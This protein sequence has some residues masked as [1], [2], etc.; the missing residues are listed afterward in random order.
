[1]KRIL[2]I[3]IIF[4]CSFT[5]FAQKS[6]KLSFVG[7]IDISHLTTTKVKQTEESTH[8]IFSNISPILKN[9]QFTMA[10]LGTIHR[11][12]QQNKFGTKTTDSRNIEIFKGLYNNH[13]NFLNLSTIQV[14]PD[15]LEN[16]LS[17]CA[18]IKQTSINFVGIT[19]L[20]EST[21]YEHDGITYGV[22][23]FG[24]NPYTP[25]AND[26]VAIK[27]LI[28][29][30]DSKCDIVV[31][32]FNL[33]NNQKLNVANTPTEKLGNHIKRARKF[34][35]TCIDSGADIVIGNGYPTILP[36]ELY[37]D[38]LI[39]YGLGSFYTRP[40]NIQN[41][42][43]LYSPVID[44]EMYSD[45]LFKEAQIHS[46]KK[47]GI[48][49]PIADNAMHSVK[50]IKRLSQE[51]VNDSVLSI[52]DNGKIVSSLMN[53]AKLTRQLIDI[54]KKHIGKRYR[55]GTMGPMTFD[56]SGFTSY[57]YNQI[58]I[59]LK[60]SSREQYTMGESVDRSKLRPGDLVFFKGSATAR[61][62]NHVGI[63]VSVDHKTNNF[64]FIHATPSRGIVIDDYGHMAYYIKRYVGA[65]RIISD[66]KP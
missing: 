14:T 28:T 25:S 17:A 1:M 3:I 37:L 50:T 7:K 66:K 62:I 48:S 30:L 36:V 8:N 46:F 43:R 45:G 51:Y 64:K 10:S 9:S 24:M 19:P 31:V 59:K 23:S 47:D 56:C 29:S 20:Y 53:A 40:T 32:A 33:S 2:T 27:Q 34:A 5:L 35:H 18:D 38:R 52:E 42:E 22:A 63:V 65:K 58:G 61:T 49:A 4:I 15:G 13:L 6:V 41:A 39:I 11:S 60:R 26:T 54:S 16:I 57:I 21:I 55:R 44:V 12:I